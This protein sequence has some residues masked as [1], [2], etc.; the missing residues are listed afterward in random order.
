MGSLR[1]NLWLALFFACL[2]VLRAHDPGLSVANARVASGHLEIEIGFAP[3]DAHLLF[4]ENVAAATPALR[5]IWE[6]R[7][8]NSVLT[9]DETIVAM[10][11]RDNVTVRLSFSLP[12]GDIALRSLV[13][14]RLPPGHREFLTVIDAQN[15]DLGRKLLRA[16]DAT[17]SLPPTVGSAGA[18]AGA[19]EPAFGVAAFFKLGVKHIW[20]GYD[21]LLFLF[22]LL[23]V[24]RSFRSIAAI[25]SCF[26]VA[27]SITLA[28]ASTGAVEI[29]SRFVEPA[30]A[31]SI[32]FVGAENL[33]RRG[34]EPRARWAL[35]FAFGLIH[36]FGFASAL[37]DLGVGR[38]G[39]GIAMPLLT[40]NLGVE[41]GQIA[42]AALVL[43]LVWRLRRSE[44][45]LAHGVPALSCIVTVAGAYWLLA[46]TVFA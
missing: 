13:F 21:H 20:T 6:V 30:I 27:H 1:S 33:V 22:G 16:D 9:P 44:R 40:F 17:F 42:I 2:P 34:A 12:P 26:T 24:C 19:T 3:A 29:S 10:V 46:R 23:L 43:P 39:Q 45:F 11:T 37:S 7:S 8:A 14:D 41:F 25:I 4:G 31:A 15:S 35:T 28:L 18:A 36:G 38:D 5:R 32:A